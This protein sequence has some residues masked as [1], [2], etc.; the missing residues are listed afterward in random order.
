MTTLTDVDCWHHVGKW[1]KV[2]KNIKQ[3]LCGG[4]LAVA[5]TVAT[6]SGVQ[7]EDWIFAKSYYSH[8]D[9]PG[10]QYGIAPKAK[11]A[12]RRP[13]RSPGPRGH[14]RS[15]FRINNIRIWNGSNADVQYDREVWYDVQQ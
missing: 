2:M 10:Y 3:W 4:C 1:V 14:I 8:A 6:A 12:Y 11:S 5:F 15:G 7:A 13:Y 9:S